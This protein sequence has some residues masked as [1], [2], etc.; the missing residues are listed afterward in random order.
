MVEWEERKK[1]SEPLRP[2]TP[3]QSEGEKRSSATIRKV[4]WYQD[5]YQYDI[6]YINHTLILSHLLIQYFIK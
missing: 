3:K 2:A 4:L 1:T 5:L 6:T